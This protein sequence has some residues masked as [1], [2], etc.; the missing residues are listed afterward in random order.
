MKPKSSLSSPYRMF[1][2]SS[3]LFFLSSF[4]SPMMAAIIKETGQGGG[5]FYSCSPTHYQMFRGHSSLYT[6][7]R[8]HPRVS[9]SFW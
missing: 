2:Q 1:F 5:G 4:L 8:V 7:P 3:Q 6:H 9:Y